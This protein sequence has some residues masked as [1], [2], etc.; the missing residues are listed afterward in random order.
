[1]PNLIVLNNLNFSCFKQYITEHFYDHMENLR[2]SLEHQMVLL[3]QYG[4]LL[5]FISI[6]VKVP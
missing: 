6:L 1:M 2:H 3:I 4:S 5:Y